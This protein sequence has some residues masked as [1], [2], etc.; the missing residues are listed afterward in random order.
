LFFSFL[1]PGAVPGCDFKLPAENA[2]T[3][4]TFLQVIENKKKKTSKKL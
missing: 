1:P 2:D 4:Q 3:R